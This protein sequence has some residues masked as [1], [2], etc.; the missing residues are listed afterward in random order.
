[1][2]PQE[3]S[4]N[5][6]D[7]MASFAA[8]FGSA[9]VGNNFRADDARVACPLFQAEYGGSTPTSALQLHI[10]KITSKLAVKL[11]KKWHSRMPQLDCYNICAPCFVAECNNLYYAIAMWSLPIAANRITNGNQCLELRRMAIAPDA[12]K[13]TASR[14]LGIMARIIRKERPDI[15]RLLSY[16]D[17]EVHKGTIYAAA[18]WKAVRTADFVSWDNHSKRPGKI[19]QSHA[20]KVRWELAIRESANDQAHLQTPGE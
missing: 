12:P 8:A 10:G 17:T 9:T 2:T 3:T 14:M 1:M 20:P 19:N 16:Q 7:A 5:T 11:N 13:N 6:G 15:I 18:G 4:E